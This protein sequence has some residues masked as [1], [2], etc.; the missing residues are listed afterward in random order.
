MADQIADAAFETVY[1][2]EGTYAPDA[3]ETRVPV[4]AEHVARMLELRDRG[5]VLEAGGFADMTASIMLVRAE[6]DG[7]GARPLPER[8]VHP[9]RGLGRAALPADDAGHPSIGAARPSVRGVVDP[10]TRAIATASRSAAEAM[11]CHAS[12]P[13]DARPAG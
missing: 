7:G 5:V 11:T 3:A 4:R 1:V 8:R 13:S 6:T 12:N 9:A 10:G 2:I